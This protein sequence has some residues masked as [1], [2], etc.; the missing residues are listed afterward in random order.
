MMRTRRARASFLAMLLSVSLSGAIQASPIA[1]GLENTPRLVGQGR[2]SVLFWDIY[3][4][5]LF[6][7]DGRYDPGQP[8][9]LVLHYLRPVSGRDIAETS[10]DEIRKQ[11][12]TDPVILADW[13]A[14]LMHVFPDIARGDEL[15]GTYDDSGG[16]FHLNGALIGEISD[17]ELSR[18][19]FDIWLSEATSQPR[20]RQRLLGLER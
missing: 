10:I 5:R 13:Q 3:E 8:L 9:A 17:P 11:G 4:I 18:R 19:F 15:V 6:T 7:T 1:S 20:L 16:R 12:M 2:L 14:Q